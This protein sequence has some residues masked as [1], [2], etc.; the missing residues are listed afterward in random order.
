MRVVVVGG[1]L[2]GLVA[3]WRLQRAGAGVTLLEA[4][5]RTGG[6][7]VREK[8]GGAEFE[9]AHVVVPASA[10]ALFG[11]VR[12]LGLAAA[13][14]R[15]PLL[16]AERIAGER[17]T[18]LDLAGGLQGLNGLRRR[19]L[20]RLLEWFGSQL[21]PRLPERGVRLDDRSIADFV[22]LYV[23][24]RC[25]PEHLLPLF[26]SEFGLD[27]RDTSRL[28]LMNLLDAH[29][30]LQAGQVFGLS[31]LGDALRAGLA[32]VR[33]ESEVR[34]IAADGTHV[35][36]ASGERIEAD[37]VVAAVCAP[38][39][40][41]LAERL[42]PGERAFFDAAARVAREHLI[43][44]LDEPL[45]Q[46]RCWIAEGPLAAIVPADAQGRLVRLIPRR[47]SEDEWMMHARRARPVLIRTAHERAA[48][49]PGAAPGFGIGHFRRIAALR[50]AAEAE[51]TRRLYFADAS[52]VAPHAEGEVQ[53]AER[54]ASQ[55]LL[56]A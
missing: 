10:P 6:R 21:D 7:H 42:L 44:V 16:E 38:R 13:V 30:R 14:Q 40:R 31:A 19:R 27:S 51:P 11:L 1:G 34:S 8:L 55:V 12:E 9:P 29:G 15:V 39:V 28:L 33:L 47:G 49:S 37:A 54:A 41:E 56:S 24:R 46:P 22:R 3:A 26:E 50:T 2:A 45:A 18:K 32:D 5:T 48:C 20:W 17:R 36:L 43:V 52:L 4:R 53:S 25:N 23:G 35:A